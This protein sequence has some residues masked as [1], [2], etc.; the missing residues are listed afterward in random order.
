MA[1]E[2]HDQPCIQRLFS[3]NVVPVSEPFVKSEI[4]VAQ[5][6]SVM[7]EQHTTPLPTPAPTRA[8]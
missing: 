3:S 4:D 5:A 6:Q 8:V 1:K 2:P 7:I